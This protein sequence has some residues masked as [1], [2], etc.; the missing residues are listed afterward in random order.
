MN[1]ASHMAHHK[2][3]KDKTFSHCKRGHA[4][5]PGNLYY[6]KNPR[7]PRRCQTC[8]REYMREWRQKH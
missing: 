5:A 4:L 7:S 6:S 2:P 1:R 8:A 3:R